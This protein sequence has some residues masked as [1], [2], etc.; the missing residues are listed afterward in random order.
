MSFRR[1][2]AAAASVVLLVAGLGAALAAVQAGA[3]APLVATCVLLMLA[4]AFAA[5]GRP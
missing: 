5:R 4:I 3:V 1:V 2:G